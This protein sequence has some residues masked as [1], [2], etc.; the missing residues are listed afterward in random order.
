MKGMKNMDF[1]N[2]KVMEAKYGNKRRSRFE[3]TLPTIERNKTN[4]MLDAQKERDSSL[5]N[6]IQDFS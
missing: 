4:N 6:A 1:I 3:S 5:N 2:Q